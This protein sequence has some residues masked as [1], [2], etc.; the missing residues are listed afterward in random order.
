[1]TDP[2]W[3]E[4]DVQAVLVNP[5]YAVTI[6][7]RLCGEHEPMIDRAQWVSA[8]ARLIEQIGAE[9]WLNRL[10]R[11]LESGGITDEPSPEPRTPPPLPKNRQQRRLEQRR[12]SKSEG[13]P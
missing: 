5:F 4:A 9:A 6:A 7:P 10:L 11:V 12:R 3:T 8:N 13:R 2:E 1:M